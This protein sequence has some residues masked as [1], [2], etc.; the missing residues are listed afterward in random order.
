MPLQQGL[1][2]L[3]SIDELRE[4][5][6]LAAQ[7]VDPYDSA[8]ADLLEWANGA[9]DI[10]PSPLQPLVLQDTDNVFV[11]DAG[12]AY[13]LGLAY[14]L[15][16]D[17]RYAAASRRTIRAWVDQ[18]STTA[19]TCPDSGGCGTSLIIGRAGAGFAMGAELLEAPSRGRPTIARS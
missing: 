1:G 11:D 6:Q 14:G 19:D 13:G 15:T 16:G 5:G 18:T 3:V 2:Y 12:R 7:G 8:V 4:R 9:V 17:E 10:K